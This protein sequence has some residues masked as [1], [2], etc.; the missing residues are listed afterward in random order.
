MHIFLS[1]P[2]FKQNT[3]HIIVYFQESQNSLLTPTAAEF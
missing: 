2:L 3:L 1:R